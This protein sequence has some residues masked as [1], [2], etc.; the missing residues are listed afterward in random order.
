MIHG[1][2]AT[3]VHDLSDGGLLIE[4]AEMA[5]AG[6]IGAKLDASPEAIVPHAWWFGE[7]QGRYI[8]TVPEAQL[9]GV[10]TK[11]KAVEVRCVQIG[12]TGGNELAVAGERAV[13]I[14]ALNHAFESWLPGYMAGKDG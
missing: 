13:H 8:V 11:L 12:V 4:L 14:K 7:D 5:I 6:G 10:L 3:S 2:T 9:L 1:G